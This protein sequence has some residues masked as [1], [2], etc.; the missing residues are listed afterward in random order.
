MYKQEVNRMK[1]SGLRVLSGRAVAWVAPLLLLGLTGGCLSLPLAEPEDSEKR[2]AQDLALAE[3]LR[4]RPLARPIRI[5]RESKEQLAGSLRKE[6]DK[7]ENVVFLGET[8]RLL[9]AFRVL[10]PED[11]LTAI[12]LSVMGEQVAAYYD[13]EAKRVAYIEGAGAS[14]TNEAPFPGMERFVYVHEFCHAIEDSHFDLERLSR[15]SL[16]DLDRNLALTSVVEGSAV[17]V[18]MDGACAGAP[19]NSALPVGAWL[20]GLLAKADLSDELKGQAAGCPPFLLGALVRPYLDGAVFVNRLRREAGWGAVDALYTNRLPQ[21]TAE[22]LFPE[23]RFLQGFR[24]AALRLPDAYFA[25]R[26]PAATNTLGALGVALWLGGDTLANP[27]ERRFLAGWLGD[28][29]FLSEGADGRLEATWL[30]LWEETGDARTFARLAG[31][32]L[33][34]GGFL[35]WGVAREGRRVALTWSAQAPCGCGP[36]A[37]AREALRLA[38]VDGGDRP[39]WWRRKMAALPMPVRFP[40]YEGYSSGFEA[41]GGYAADVCGGEGFYRFTLASGV[42][43]RAEA[44]PDRHYWGALCGTLR[45]VGDARSEFTH[46]RVPLAATWFSRG[47]GEER[48]FK[49]RVLLGLLA[50]GDETR[51]RVLLVPVWR[52]APAETSAPPQTAH[53]AK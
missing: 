39:G 8:E 14:A 12:Y 4:G 19:L 36:A 30:T 20:V 10:R 22:I 52:A 27:S 44:N 24:P 40:S 35:G 5:E 37:R 31:K 45:H 15:D 48:R 18:G 53:A 32:R 28:R 51:A 11:D 13:P 6:L 34:A 3:R 42:G 41:L 43:L 23:R 25:G 17:L 21:T 47:T 46:W 33:A 9:K 1:Q 38:E 29:V 7:P 2:V 49:W 16:P 50:H 26:A